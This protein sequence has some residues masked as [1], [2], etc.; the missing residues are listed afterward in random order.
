[1]LATRR[2]LRTESKVIQTNPRLSPEELVF[3]DHGVVDALK[4]NAV[5]PV[6]VPKR[7]AKP[8]AKLDTQ[9]ELPTKGAPQA[10]LPPTLSLP[11]KETPPPEM[12]VA[13]KEIPARKEILQSVEVM[14][15]QEELP[16]KV[17]P[18]PAEPLPPKAMQPIKAEP[19]SKVDS[20]PTKS[21]P[22][23]DDL[24]DYMIDYFD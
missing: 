24:G 14:Q 6:T 1:M 7:A 18:P 15:P 8:V 17:V 12:I 19:P 13:P 9:D 5:Y 10:V 22:L 4:Y 11:P 20:K 16:P 2:A 23:M 21:S 3:W